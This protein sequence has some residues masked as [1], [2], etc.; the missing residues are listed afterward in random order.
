MLVNTSADRSETDCVSGKGG[1]RVRVINRDVQGYLINI[2]PILD[3]FRPKSGLILYD[4]Y[5]GI[6][7]PTVCGSRRKLYRLSHHNQSLALI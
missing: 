6:I 2:W 5:L 7:P 1:Y 3:Q 4:S